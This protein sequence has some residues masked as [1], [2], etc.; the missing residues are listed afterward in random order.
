MKSFKSMLLGCA[1]GAAVLAG[2]SA[3]LAEAA[4]AGPA[5]QVETLVVTA[6]KRE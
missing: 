4:P 5:T 3:A 1:T 6:Q 2:A